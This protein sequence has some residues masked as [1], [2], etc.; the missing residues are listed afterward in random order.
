MQEDR[1]NELLTKLREAF[2]DTNGAKLIFGETRTFGE[3]AVIPVAQVRYGFGGG[4]GSGKK[5]GEEQ[6]G[7]GG[8]FGGGLQVKPVGFIEVDPVTMQFRPIFDLPAMLMAIAA[9]AGVMMLKGALFGAG[10][11]GCR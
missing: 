6:Q 9:A 8:G 10:R 5:P 11:R 4:A 2:G 1:L 7:E 3:R